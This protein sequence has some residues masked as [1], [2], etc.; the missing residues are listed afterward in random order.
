MFWGDLKGGQGSFSENVMINMRSK[1]R[2]G[3]KSERGKGKACQTQGI[4]CAKTW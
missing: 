4:A 3:L 1:G 2:A